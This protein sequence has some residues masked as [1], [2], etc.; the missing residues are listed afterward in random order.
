MCDEFAV[1][2]PCKSSRPGLTF[3]RTRFHITT[4]SKYPLSEK[5]RSPERLFLENRSPGDA[6][7]LIGA[8][9]N[10][11]MVNGLLDR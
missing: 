9:E 10:R 5:S 3:G 1:C 8:F 4:H 7:G 6:H 2:S 11:L